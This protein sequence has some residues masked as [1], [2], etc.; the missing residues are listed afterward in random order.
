MPRML[1]LYSGL[2]GASEA[3][4][5]A[6]WDVVRVDNNPLLEQVPNTTIRDIL[7][8]ESPWHFGDPFDFIWASPP[9]TEFSNAYSAP[10][11]VARRE[12]RD[13]KPDLSLVVKAKEII[14]QLN[15]KWWCIENVS[16]ASKDIS[17][18]LGVPPW[19]VI[20]PY[21]LW[22]RFP[23]IHLDYDWT[24]SKYEDDVGPEDPLRANKRGK[25]PLEISSAFLD[26]ISCQRQISDWVI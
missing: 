2:G 4:L 10:R 6:G 17:R 23:F 19:Q 15:P 21:F 24:R 1:D 16:G 22:G 9:C 7:T 20:G 11:A 14:D 25:I 5:R 18:A 3:F 13:F 26:F 12:G 8:L